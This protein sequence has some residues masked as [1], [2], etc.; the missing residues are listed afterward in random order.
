M[1]YNGWLMVNYS[2][3][4]NNNRRLMIN[5][6]WSVD[7]NWCSVYNNVW[8]VIHLRWGMV[9]NRRS[10]NDYVLLLFVPISSLLVM[11]VFLNMFC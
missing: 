7:E 9:D 10:V 6:W 5:N 11:L 4:V 8:S 2:W 3:S 1:E